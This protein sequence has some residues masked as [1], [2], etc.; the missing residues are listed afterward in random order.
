MFLVPVPEFERPEFVKNGESVENEKGDTGEEDDSDG[1][2]SGGLGNGATFGSD[3]YILNP[4]TGEYVKLGDLIHTY[5][6]IMYEKL[7]NGSY[8]EEQKEAIT[9]YFD[10]LYSGIEE[11]KDK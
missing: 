2:H 1:V 8:T 9:K 11:R 5:Y 7:Q 4:Q 6:A 3:D 10:L